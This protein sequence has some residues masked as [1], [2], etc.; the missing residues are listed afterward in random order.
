VRPCFPAE[1]DE[2][3]YEA[4]IA[5]VLDGNRGWKVAVIERSPEVYDKPRAITADHEA[6]RVFQE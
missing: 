3:D 2:I 6:L 1:A 4:E 5:V